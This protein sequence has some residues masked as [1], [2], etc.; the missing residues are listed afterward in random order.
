MKG[1]KGVIS[2]AIAFIVFALII[3][4][5]GAVAAPVLTDIT[6]KMFAAGDDIM[7]MT[8]DGLNDI[9]DTTIRDQINASLQSARGAQ[10][11][12]IDVTTSLYKYAW[13]GIV[14][15]L[16]LGMFLLTRRSVE[17]QGLA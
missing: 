4:L 12:N 15:I 13:I 6:V 8:Q 2:F 16:F 17:T 14:G 9:N 5:I 7:A 3:V 10:Q 1:K 11:D